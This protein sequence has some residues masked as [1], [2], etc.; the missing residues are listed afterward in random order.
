MFSIEHDDIGFS[1]IYLQRV[2][3]EGKQFKLT[4]IITQIS[5]KIHTIYLV[6]LTFKS[7]PAGVGG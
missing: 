5:K 3:E 6:T 7:E 4:K 2:I 1:F